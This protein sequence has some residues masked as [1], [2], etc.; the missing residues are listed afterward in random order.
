MQQAGDWPETDWHTTRNLRGTSQKFSEDAEELEAQENARALKQ[1]IADKLEKPFPRKQRR[2]SDI[3]PSK[4]T[5]MRPPKT[6]PSG[7]KTKTKTKRKGPPPGGYNHK[8]S[9]DDDDDL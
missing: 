4:K 8:Y 7:S 3:T 2:G 6:T 5:P 1:R 9:I